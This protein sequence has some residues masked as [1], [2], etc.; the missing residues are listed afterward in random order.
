MAPNNNKPLF[1][2]IGLH[3]G[4]EGRSCLDHIVC[5]LAIEPFDTLCLVPFLATID[6]HPPEDAIKLVKVVDGKHT[7]TVGFIPR[8]YCKQQFIQDKINKYCK[9]LELY[10]NSN[11]YKQRLSQK[12]YG[13]ASCFLLKMNIYKLNIK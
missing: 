9:V 10:D 13:M 8:A 11:K 7:C 2:V 6:G 3:H 4:T 12:N 5:G 1:E